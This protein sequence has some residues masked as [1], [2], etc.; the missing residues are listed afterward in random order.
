MRSQPRQQILDVWRAV[1]RFSRRDKGQLW[2][3]VEE[4]QRNSI[5]DAEQ[6]LC[7]MHP[8]HEIDAL[9]LDT[10]DEIS[11]DVLD[12]LRPLGGRKEIPRLLVTVL[13]EYMTRYTPDSDPP[14]FDV[15][16]YLKSTDDDEP[17][18]QQKEF[19]VV[20]SFIKSISLTMSTLAFLKTYRHWEGRPEELQSIAELESI[21]KRRLTAALTHLRDSFSV[22]VFEPSSE[23]GQV[24]LSMLN[25]GERNQRAAIGELQRRLR[26][27]RIRLRDGVSSLHTDK[28]LDDEDWLFEC[29]FS[30]AT[31]SGPMNGEAGDE[32][33]VGRAEGAPYL[34]FTVA[35]MEALPDLWSER[36]TM[37]D[38][39]DPRQRELVHE[40]R[41][42]WIMTAGY[43]SVVARF[44]AE[45]W[46]LEELPWNTTDNVESDY[47]SL[48]LTSG[49]LLDV[50]RWEAVN[51]DI[52]RLAG[53]L[54][55]LA[56]RGRITRRAASD[57]PAIALHS[58][59]LRLTLSP[60][61]GAV[62]HPEMHRPIRDFGPMLFARTQRAIRRSRD[63]S[64]QN[65]LTDL[66]E[67]TLEHLWQRRIKTGYGAGLWDD[68][69]QVYP[70]LADEDSV[71]VSWEL[72]ARMV[73]GL[74]AAAKAVDRRPISGPMSVDQLDRD[75]NEADLLL[76]KF[77]L[78]TPAGS[79][80]ALGNAYGRIAAE[81]NRA[82]SLRREQPSTAAAHVDKALL[83]LDEMTRGRADESRI[84]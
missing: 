48:W 1:A 23:A 55:E 60:A 70:N 46:P 63:V 62:S 40:L 25:R 57:D 12:A 15:G 71:N 61:Q 51:E 76:A 14:I 5:S 38:L 64:T 81:L 42:R 79:G 54:T 66:A 77:E 17:T 6:L 78:D 73:E 8:A 9:R 39:L 13:T 67:G 35:A 80:S 32:Q 58:P 37:L 50:E 43:W 33:R 22:N 56:E 3:W 59:G 24:L 68:P 26:P 10:P 41:T 16:N 7:L 65:M 2:S 34:Y 27:I 69:S 4:D 53:V 28:R 30:W 47:F 45:R 18:K 21:T 29:G 52:T 49:V 82:K 31:V 36:T 83:E 19:D 11:D 75:I 72:T 84:G 74:V 20:E 44:S